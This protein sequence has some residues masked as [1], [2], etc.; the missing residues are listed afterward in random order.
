MKILYRY[1]FPVTKV[2]KRSEQIPCVRAFIEK[3]RLTYGALLFDLNDLKLQSTKRKSYLEKLAESDSFWNLTV[4]PCAFDKQTNRL[5]LSGVRPAIE[6]E[7][8]AAA[9][10]K[11]MADMPKMCSY[12]ICFDGMEWFPG[13]DPLDRADLGKSVSPPTANISIYNYAYN[14]TSYIALNVPMNEHG[15]EHLRFVEQFSAH[16]AGLSYTKETVF[17]FSDAE[18][19]ALRTATGQAESLLRDRAYVDIPMQSR[20]SDQKETLKL[21]DSI[22][23]TF[24]DFHFA[25]LGNGVYE[26]WRTDAY[27]HKLSVIFDYD[28][29]NHCFCAVLFYVGAGIKTAIHYSEIQE[30]YSNE[31]LCQYLAEVYEDIRE[32]ERTYAPQLTEYYPNVPSWFEW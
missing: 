3:S 27:H 29:E 14:D 7:S 9:L 1:I 22:R 24:V 25:P 17:V 15:A 26:A 31:L 13:I 19:E 30:L 16:L 28:R 23:K 8:V 6:E 20:P 12:L 10:E 5:S 11:P 4:D 2:L 18:Q 32:F 21:K